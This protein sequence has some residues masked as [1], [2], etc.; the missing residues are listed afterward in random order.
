MTEEVIPIDNEEEQPL[1][2]ILETPPQRVRTFNSVTELSTYL[3]LVRP[4]ALLVQTAHK[5]VRDHSKGLYYQL[6]TED[7]V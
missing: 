3:S 4:S 1:E 2:G 7:Q 6:T 5:D